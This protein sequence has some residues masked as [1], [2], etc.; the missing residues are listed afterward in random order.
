MFI[1]DSPINDLKEDLLDREN[2][3]KHLG[4]AICNWKEKESLVIA[5]N[6]PWGIGKSSIINMAISN[7]KNDIEDEKPTIISFNPWIYSNLSNLTANFF[8]E[9]SKELE[10]QNQT[11]KDKQIAAK[12]KLYSNLLNV[13]PEKTILKVGYDKLLMALGFTGMSLSP[14]LDWLGL[15][16]STWKTVLFFGG[17]GLV[18]AQFVQGALGKL[19]SIFEARAKTNEKTAIDIK[20]EITNVLLERNKKLVI[21]I[22]DID[23]LTQGEIKEIFRLIKI[24]ANFPNTIYLLSFDRKI[25]E[26]NLDVA[27]G[28]SSATYMEKIIQVS[29]DVPE[30]QENLIYK[31]FFEQLD[32]I[33]SLLPKA[34]ENYF[35]EDS[36]YWGNIFHSGIKCFLRNLRNVKRFISSLEFTIVQMQK[37]DVLEVNPIDFIAIEAIRVFVPDFHNFIKHNKELFTST[38]NSGMAQNDDKKQKILKE[39]IANLTGKHQEH[40]EKIIKY[41]FPQVENLLDRGSS[42]YGSEWITTWSNNLRA[43][44][45][46]H[47]D[48]YFVYLPKGSSDKISE[49]ELETTLKTINDKDKFEMRLNDYVQKGKIRNLLELFQYN[50][51]DNVKFPVMYFQNI[52]IALLNLID[53][54]SSEREGLTDVGA[55]IEVIRIIYQI[56]KRE[57]DQDNNYILLR[58]ATLHSKSLYGIV[59]LIS[60][61][62]P[63]ENNNNE[64]DLLKEEHLFALQKLCV[65]R[66]TE[67][68][69]NNTLLDNEKFT[70]ILYRWK[71]WGLSSSNDLFAFIEKVSTNNKLLLRFLEGFKMVDTTYYLSNYVPSKKIA[72]RFKELNDF[73]DDTEKI[74]SKLVHIKENDHLLY[75]EHQEIIDL[76]LADYGKNNDFDPFK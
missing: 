33:I 11:D 5:L 35:N 23:R 26:E 56:L 29:F 1:G 19:A 45:P 71:E 41:L 49:Y 46:T 6:G 15:T 12:L 22:D 52:I 39:G 43:C 64:M 8:D 58:Q 68:A 34:A 72:F 3:S 27:L 7:I 31:Y 59:R 9:L 50:T 63:R 16:S 75:K 54:L 36:T 18:L 4:K 69:N 28:L 40:I 47:F 13:L 70:Y 51:K 73:V 62:T 61:Q 32:R 76:F 24:N 17:F 14:N 60:L 55:D 42:S 30:A 74:K 66:I 38:R 10:I 2:F 57:D 20:D 25:V 44:S 37:E 48:S 21:I 53:S 67:T 65:E